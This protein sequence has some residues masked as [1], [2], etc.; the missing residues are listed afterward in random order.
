MQLG[1]YVREHLNIS[2]A[3]EECGINFV[4]CGDYGC[5]N[6]VPSAQEI[7]DFN[8][9]LANIGVSLH[10]IS[11][12]LTQTVINEETNKISMLLEKNISVSVNDWGALYKIKNSIKSENNVYIGRLLT[13]SIHDWAWSSVYFEKE[14]KSEIEYLVQNNFNHKLKIDFFKGWNVKGIEVNVYTEGEESYR[15]IK[16]QGFEIVGYTDNTILAVSRACPVAR[17]NGVNFY[18]QKCKKYC[19]AKQFE[20]L[21]AEEKQKNIYPKMELRGNILY[22]PQNPELLWHGYNKLV[23]DW[24][25]EQEQQLIDRLNRVR[26]L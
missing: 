3:I 26:T 6:I 7:I 20:M 18:T 1:I 25:R 23:F 11:P 2:K 8:E 24:R 12:K 22:K 13:K 15:H 5:T 9:R 21:P 4:I 10:Y 16:E 17:L 14:N 19:L